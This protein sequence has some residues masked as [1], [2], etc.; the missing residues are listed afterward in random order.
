MA[1]FKDVPA[2]V[3]EST[4]PVLRTK[5]D[6]LRSNKVQSARIV[7]SLLAEISSILAIESSAVAFKIQQGPEELVSHTGAHFIPETAVPNKYALVPILRSG[8]SMVEPFLNLL[9]EVEAPVYH[10]GIFRDKV[11][12]L[13]VEYYSK[14]PR[15]SSHYDI[16]YVLDPIIATGGTAAAAVNLLK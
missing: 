14:L 5:L 7:R 13:P 12:L 1:H 10:L 6:Y 15:L 9:P 3:H 16:V 4:H 2:N 11:S 8:L